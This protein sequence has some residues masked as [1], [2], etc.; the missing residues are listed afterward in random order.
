MFFRFYINKIKLFSTAIHISVFRKFLSLIAALFS[1]NEFVEFL[2]V[3][4]YCLASRRKALEKII[5][6]LNG[7][8]FTLINREELIGLYILRIIMKEQAKIGLIV[9]SKNHFISR[10]LHNIRPLIYLK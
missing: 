7:E 2:T 9:F 1:I 3:G 5:I 10:T 4:F 6:L 8:Y